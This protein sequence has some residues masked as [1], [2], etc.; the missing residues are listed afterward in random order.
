METADGGGGGTF[1]VTPADLFQAGQAALKAAQTLN[2][3]GAK[4]GSALGSAASAAGISQ[5][6]ESLLS[7][8][9][10]WMPF[11][12]ALAQSTSTMGQNLE[13]AANGY[14]KAD[15]AV[16]TRAAQAGGKG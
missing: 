6:H 4:G 12:A 16:L 1:R 9:D 3:F 8:K 10:S 14:Q 2:D 15:N 5:L 7:F 11:I 13:D